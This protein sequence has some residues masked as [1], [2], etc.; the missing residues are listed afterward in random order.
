MHNKHEAY[1]RGVIAAPSV[2]DRVTNPENGTVEKYAWFDSF[3]ALTQQIINEPK[4]MTG[5]LSPVFNTTYSC[6]QLHQRR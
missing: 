6:K 4:K 3:E 2:Q 5:L 1:K